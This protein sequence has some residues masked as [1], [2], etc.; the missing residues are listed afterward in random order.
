MDVWCV[1][2]LLGFDRLGGGIAGWQPRLALQ[3][4]AQMA[5]P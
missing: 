1:M 3:G 4:D 5:K 2:S